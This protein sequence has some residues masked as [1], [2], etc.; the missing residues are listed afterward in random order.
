MT[1][2]PE[3]YPLP[4]ITLNGTGRKTLTDEHYAAYKAAKIALNALHGVTCNGRDYPDWPTF[5]RARDER[6]THLRNLHELIQYLE[7]HI[8]HIQA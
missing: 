6:S 1:T 2:T 5:Y 3:G 4:C 7:A 8:T